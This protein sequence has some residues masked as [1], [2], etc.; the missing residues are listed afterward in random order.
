MSTIDAGL[1][2]YTEVAVIGRGGSATVYRARQ[3][4]F[5]RDV[6]V[7]VLAGPADP[8]VGDRFH[9][10]C[11][12]LGALSGHPNIV[13]VYEAGS[14]PDG[15][16]FV[17]MEH[18]PGGS[19]GDRVALGG[20]I[21][22][23]QAVSIGVELAGALESAHRAGVVHGDVTPGNVLFSRFG[24]PKLTD[25]GMAGGQDG[26]PSSGGLWGTPAHVSPER[27]AGRPAGPRAD[28]YGLASTI[29]TLLTGAAPFVRPTDA[30]LAP[31]VARTAEEPPPDLRSRGVPT[32]LCAVL[33]RAL[34]KDPDD[35]QSG[36]A[37]FGRQLQAVQ[38]AA[39][40]PITPMVLEAEPDAAG[41]EP[42]GLVASPASPV[43][44]SRQWERRARAGGLA[45]MLTALVAVLVPAHRPAVRLAQVFQDDFDAGQGWAVAD[46]AVARLR[47]DG[48]HY[49]VALKQSRQQVMSDTSL[50]GPVFGAPLSARDVSVRVTAS[51][52]SGTGLFG[53]MC[54]QAPG[55][56]AYYEA[57]VGVDGTARILKHNGRLL[58]E[59]AA[60]PAP[61]VGTRSVRLRLDC[62]GGPGA[63]TAR[64]YLDGR[65]LIEVVD[66]H[67]LA[68]GSTGVVVASGDADHADIVFDDFV[69]LGP[70]A[71]R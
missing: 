25:F 43:R 57:L 18:L 42:D 47:Y 60:A 17:V 9:A 19:L 49:L 62:I 50:R 5:G 3:P 66:R 45:L 12:A 2:A 69:M 68:A 63:T 53:V 16:L 64:L 36:A 30:G 20:P 40:L 29:H 31:L 44:R 23:Q 54:R 14:G 70:V 7:K 41:T 27:L 34:A 37:Q 48:G 67:G 13:A 52:S 51:S 26:G 59:M 55:Q 32:D 71:R 56:A 35:R 28:V 65:R 11:S 4:E 1:R 8:L 46:D 10:E 39:G 24:V 61:G 21:G 58:S 6:A 38:A 33:E 22:W 15:D